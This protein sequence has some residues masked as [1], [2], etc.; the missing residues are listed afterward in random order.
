MK[1]CS[2]C[3]KVTQLYIDDDDHSSSP[4]ITYTCEDCTA[5]GT[6]NTL[7]PPPPPHLM[8]TILKMFD[9]DSPQRQVRTLKGGGNIQLIHTKGVLRILSFHPT[10]GDRSEISVTREDM[11]KKVI[12]REI[13]LIMTL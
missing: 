1:T 11:N 7:S 8:E 2:R 9:E 3:R 4:H 5:R 6:K 13:Y 10:T 12:P